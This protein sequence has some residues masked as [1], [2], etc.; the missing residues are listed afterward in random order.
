[1]GAADSLLLTRARLPG[2]DV[3]DLRL[4][5]GVVV[6][7]GVLPAMPGEQVL[8]LD[9]YLVLPALAEPH[10]HLD[11]A[12][13]S[14]SA[15]VGGD[16]I[17]AMSAHHSVLDTQSG[18]QIAA[19]AERA[20]LLFL[21]NGCTAIRAHT[22]CG[23]RA[24][25]SAIVALSA[26]RDRLAGLLDIQIVAHIGGPAPGTPW[27]DHVTILRDAVAAGADV[28]GGNP[29]LE[30]DPDQAMDAC[31]EVAVDTGRAV[32]FHTDETTDPTVL[33]VRRL[34]RWALRRGPAT[35]VA[36]SHCISLG[37]ATPAVQSEVAADLA[38][39]RVSV[40]TLPLTSLHLQG[41]TGSA[42][43]RGLTAL[44]AL[45]AAGVPVAAG[46]DNIQDAFNPVGR[47]DPLEIA[48]MLVVAG[49]RGIDDAL[50]MVSDTARGV[51]GL[52]PAGPRPG[53]VADLVAVRCRSVSEAIALGPADRLVFKAGRL[54]AGRSVDSW[55]AGPTQRSL[56]A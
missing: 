37:S 44:D 32:D 22:G 47:C 7:S 45:A 33:T 5:Q 4:R 42:G 51:M 43:N 16:L 12:F 21:A 10:V 18:E 9:G 11:K 49:H 36:A 48:S 54:V 15:P 40:V 39:A 55:I 34:T 29:F 35:A 46:S 27:R 8:D 28:V 23:R 26:V 30:D 6:A 14:I 13:T 24:G 19:R 17:A 2:G 3:V 41:R 31:L 52:P 56:P 53:A 38:E 1:V 25:I 50:R 20:A